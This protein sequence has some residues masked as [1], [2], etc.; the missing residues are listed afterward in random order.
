MKRTKTATVLLLDDVREIREPFE[1]LLASAGYKV[2]SPR[3]E[4]EAIDAVRRM[5]PDLII[6]RLSQSVF[7]SAAAEHAVA[8]GHRIR[9]LAELADRVPIVV[10]NGGSTEDGHVTEMDG[11]V[12]LIAPEAFEELEQLLGRLV[13]AA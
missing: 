9:A 6:V 1:I 8:A 10:I 2:K 11:N 13:T 12:H 3:N 4:E 7:K 5:P